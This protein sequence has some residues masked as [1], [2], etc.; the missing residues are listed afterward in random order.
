MRHAPSPAEWREMENTHLTWLR[1][2]HVIVNAPNDGCI[3]VLAGSAHKATFARSPVAAAATFFHDFA[4]LAT[5]AERRF[6]NACV[7]AG[8]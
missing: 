5:T 8:H 1:L 2:A 6:L 3:K 4:E 7:A